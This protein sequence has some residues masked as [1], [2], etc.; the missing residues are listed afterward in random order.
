[1]R[2]LAA[3]FAL[4]LAALAPLPARA[5]CGF[6]VS[7]ADA[8]LFNNA[9][10]VV[11]LRDGI[12]TVLSM[13]N[14][15]QGPPQ[16]FAMVVPVPVVLQKENVKT[17][18]REVFDHVDQLSAPRLVQYW[19]QDPCQKDRHGGGIA[20][21]SAAAP[22]AAERADAAPGGRPK[23]RVEAEFAVGEYEVVILSADDST[24]LDAWLRQNHYKIPD[25]AEPVLR[26]YVQTG[27]KFFV[28]KVNVAKV[29]FEKGMA[30]LSPLRFHYD[31]DR[32]Q[33]P[34][35]LGLLN[36]KGTQDLI[37]QIL[38]KGQRYE[39]AN[40]PNVAIPTNI[41][42]GEA[43]LGSFG[44][45]YVQLFDK[46]L[47]KTPR[48]AVTEYAWNAGMC[49]P[50]PGPALDQGDLNA[51]GGDVVPGGLT[52]WET[53]LTRLHLRYTKD[54]L[55]EDLVFRAAPALDGGHEGGGQEAR[56]TPG[57]FSQFQGRY[58][59]RHPW[60]G[61]IT[62]PDPQF[63]RWGG[64]PGKVEPAR[65][66]AF[67]PRD[68]AT[69]ASLVAVDVPALG[70][71]STLS[72]PARSYKV[73]FTAYLRGAKAAVALGALLGLAALAALLRRTRRPS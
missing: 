44:A 16:D 63:G 24:A 53:T 8:K 11:L 32:F 25:A 35:R 54:S 64:R 52:A 34:V 45:F 71:K 7:G 6:Y 29:R 33:L 36:S 21:R 51:L 9:T 20:K 48:A 5:F 55:G 70:V 57:K 61:E 37:V 27:F 42:L 46:T 50:C 19:E 39:A 30:T 72:A 13:A 1:V 23:V 15:Y 41:E 49:D 59:V 4:G 65:D 2:P 14:N 31:D 12:R 60:Q 40:Y 22:M 69:L 73:P 58:V 66:L 38:A 10:Q 26:P 56:T 18:K 47:E 62:C 28:A 67:A 43:A 3:A 68:G 17:L